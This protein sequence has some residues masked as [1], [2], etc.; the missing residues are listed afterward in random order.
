M[1]NYFSLRLWPVASRRTLDMPKILEL[2]CG[3]SGFGLGAEMAG[4]ELV[5]AVDNDPFTTFSHKANYPH[6][7]LLLADLAHMSGHDLLETLGLK[8]GDIDGVIGGPPCQGFSRGGL[9]NPED[10][11]N[12]LL[13]RFFILVSYINPA[14][15]VM[16]NV[17]GLLDRDNEAVVAAAFSAIPNNYALFGPIKLNAKNFGAPTNRE[18]VILVGYDPRRIDLSLVKAAFLYSESNVNVEDAIA[19]LPNPDV[20]IE[21]ADGF[22]W[23]EYTKSVDSISQYAAC[24]RVAS[25]EA[26]QPSSYLRHSGDRS[27]LVSGIN[28]TKHTDAVRNRFDAL[29]QGCRDKTSKALRLDWAG[30]CPT[31]RA[32]T[33]SDRGSYQALRPI[34]PDQPRMI[35]IREAARLQGFPDW[36]Q[37]H[38]TIWHSFR[39][40][41]NSVSP[42]F[43][44]RLLTVISQQLGSD[45]RPKCVVNS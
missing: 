24:M 17:P 21:D 7:N 34:H 14:F 41:G 16:E 37:F 15:F 35:T 20:A 11:R 2:F 43:S 12:N 9:R 33:G 26:L 45:F 3:A 8:H 18:R 19:D 27:R 40:I 1:Q 4:F 39:M 44:K 28:P 5:A 38:P 31:L 13:K 29:P 22:F 32:G 23:G 10:P 25:K 6:C 36:F 30:L 42:V